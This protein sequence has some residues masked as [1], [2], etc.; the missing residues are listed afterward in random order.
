MEKLDLDISQ[1]V[2][3]L[4]HHSICS[5][6]QLES[7]L[8]MRAN[9]QQ[10]GFSAEQL[11]AKLRTSVMSANQTLASLSSHG[12]VE[13]CEDGSYRYA[14]APEVDRVVEELSG[15]YKVRRFSVIQAIY[16]RP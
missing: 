8:L 2:V 9:S 5:V 1:S 15:L 10:A 13:R 16:N 14:G 11:A 7:L 12:L 6:E 4:L 3:D